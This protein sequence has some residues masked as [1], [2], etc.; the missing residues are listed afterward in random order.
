MST[1]S[2]SVRLSREVGLLAMLEDGAFLVAALG[3]GIPDT[4]EVLPNRDPKLAWKAAAVSW[5]LAR[6]ADGV[7]SGFVAV[8]PLPARERAN[9]RSLALR[10]PNG[11][12]IDMP[13]RRHPGGL[14]AI[15]TIVADEAGS[16]FGRVVD[17]LVEALLSDGGG[18]ARARA[19][20]TLVRIAAKPTGYI[21]IV[22]APAEEEI[23]V[24][25]WAADLP[26]GHIRVL[27]AGDPPLAA[28][29]SCATYERQDLAG[30]GRGFAG[31]LEP[32]PLPDIDSLRGL[33][34]RADDGWRSLD[35]YER[36]TAIRARDIPA[37]LRGVLPQ[38]VAPQDTLARLRRTAHRF[39][40]RETVSQVQEP[41]RLGIDLAVEAKGSGILVAGWLLDPKD[42][43][44]EVRLCAGAESAVISGDWTRV[45]R[46]DVAG[47]FASDPLFRGLAG[48]GRPAGFIAFAPRMTEVEGE[49]RIELDLGEGEPTCFFPI[50]PSRAPLTQ[51][52]ARLLAS[53]DPRAAAAV[54]AVE[55]QFGPMLRACQ[56]PGM[57]A[58]ETHDLGDARRFEDA[59][60]ALV[61]GADGRVGE[62]THLLAIL[63]TG[64][65]ARE[66]PIVLAAPGDALDPVAG[67]IARLAAFYDLS[68]RLVETERSADI[69]DALSAGA[70]ATGAPTLALLSADVMPLGDDWL[71]RLLAAYR[72][73]GERAIV[74]PTIL[75]ED[76][77]VRW[78]GAWLDDE[79]GRR[80]LTAPNLGLPVAAVDTAEPQEV[81]VGTLE[82]CVLSRAAFEA[83]A[84]TSGALLGS[85]ARNLDIALR[86][87]LA[88]TPAL[89][90]PEVQMI[91]AA[92]ASAEASL[93]ARRI[94]RWSLDHRWSL[95]IAN[96]RR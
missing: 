60:V 41:V 56:R 57:A 8:F 91:A 22:G 19:A 71:V 68:V 20:N 93:L 86:I 24:Q 43:V 67:E 96:M 80:Q 73:R 55:R 69:F 12:A 35:I 9:L 90:L 84:E 5:P 48:D 39:D 21:E 64:R 94:D 25:G 15:F 28:E 50:T 85:A 66:Y 10:L 44:R 81:S 29:L 51:A 61:I 54:S 16:A 6:A 95:A 87:R 63:A 83:A 62:T 42:R 4:V 32:A 70:V 40:G 45:A 33:F 38:M 31:I 74:C 75:F 1:E 11:K 27:A 78:A 89:W 79:D 72:L 3:D 46:N 92:D 49:T 18:P 13:L 76:R 37:H 7:R 17:G 52:L 14:D 59:S 58:K 23:F 2:A 77:S 34:F 65:H 47:A 82:C 88:G 36:R 53:I 30:R 26:A